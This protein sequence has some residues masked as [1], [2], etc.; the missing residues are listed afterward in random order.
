MADQVVKCGKNLSWD[1][2]YGGE[3]APTAT[4]YFA[5]EKVLP[6]ERWVTKC[7]YKVLFFT[8]L[9]LSYAALNFKCTLPFVICTL[10]IN[11]DRSLCTCNNKI[12]STGYNGQYT[13]RSNVNSKQFKA[14]KDIFVIQT[15]CPLFY[16]HRKFE[17]LSVARNKGHPVLIQRPLSQHLLGAFCNVLC[18]SFQF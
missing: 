7:R 6:S 3:P 15:G 5:D 16:G 18:S 8:Q 9:C 11:F 10:V 17:N 2:Q 14:L 4:W 1:I 13:F 12:L